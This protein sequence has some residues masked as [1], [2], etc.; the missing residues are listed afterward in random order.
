[1]NQLI[2]G[3]SVHVLLQ[4]EDVRIILTSAFTGDFLMV[5]ISAELLVKKLCKWR[6][7]NSNWLILKD[8][9]WSD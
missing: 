3:F 8:G 9:M 4:I 7:W 1:M 6:G 5:G 2:K